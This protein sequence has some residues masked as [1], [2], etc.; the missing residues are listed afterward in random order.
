MLITLTANF[1]ALSF[2]IGSKMGEYEIKHTIKVPLVKDL[3]KAF[4]QPLRIL[5]EKEGKMGAVH[6]LHTAW[7]HR[8]G[9]HIEVFL[10]HFWNIV[11]KELCE[12]VTPVL[13]RDTHKGHWGTALVGRGIV[14]NKSCW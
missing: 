12:Q 10:L 2:Q 13:M 9:R 14:A 6:V 4:K 11:L 8:Q 5:T 1:K 3:S 7:A